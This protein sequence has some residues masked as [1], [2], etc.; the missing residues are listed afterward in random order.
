MLIDI[1]DVRIKPYVRMTQRSKWVNKQAQQYLNS[2]NTLMTLIRNQ[3]Q[4]KDYEMLPAQTPLSVAITVHTHTSQGHRA[5]LD[6]IVKA[7]LDACQGIAFKDD[8]WIDY[9]EA[10]RKIG[11]VERLQLLVSETEI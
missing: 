9:I 3:M 2:K 4:Q 5:D 11:E 6:N 10:T 8:R 1:P 7:I